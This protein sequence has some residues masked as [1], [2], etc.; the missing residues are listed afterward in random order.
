M[1]GM[2]VCVCVRVCVCV[3]VRKRRG[4]VS[5]QRGSESTYCTASYGR[6]SKCASVCVS[7]FEVSLAYQWIS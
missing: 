1:S 6:N 3:C 2:C 5:N 7:V 4:L